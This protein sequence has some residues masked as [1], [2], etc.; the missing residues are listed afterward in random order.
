MVMH[1][2]DIHCDFVE[3]CQNISWDVHIVRDEDVAEPSV[4]GKV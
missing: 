2:S 3:L 1:V 4:G